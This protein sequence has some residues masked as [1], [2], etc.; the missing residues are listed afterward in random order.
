MFTPPFSINRVLV[1]EPHKKAYGRACAARVETD[2]LQRIPRTL[3][4]DDVLLRF[5]DFS[6]LGG[7]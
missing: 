4:G 1:Y 2:L 3:S 5:G 6:S 7:S